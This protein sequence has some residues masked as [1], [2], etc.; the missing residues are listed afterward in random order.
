VLILFHCHFDSFFVPIKSR[1]GF[2]RL[3]S[4]IN[5]IVLQ[6]DSS[7]IFK[8][9]KVICC[10]LSPV[11]KVLIQG[12]ANTKHGEKDPIIL[13]IEHFENFNLWYF[14]YQGV[15]DTCLSFFIELIEVVILQR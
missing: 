10:N 13:V 5:L 14:I 4:K 8:T 6:I 9:F 12:A 15:I 11:A 3:I 7:V 1:H 2:S